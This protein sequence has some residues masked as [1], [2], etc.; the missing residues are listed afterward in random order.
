LNK[1]VLNQSS[2]TYLGS[3]RMPTYAN[4]WSTAFSTGGLTHRYVNGQLHF[5]TTSHVYSGGL[6]YETNYPGISTGDIYSAPQAQVVWNWGDVYTGK[7]ELQDAQVPGDHWTSQLSSGD[8]TYGLYY[9]QD[10]GRLYW[11]YGDWYN[12]DFPF[13]PS[14]GYSVLN[15]STG[16]V[17]GVGTWSLTD[18]PE[19]FTR[20]GTLRIPQWFADSYTG[21]RSLGVGFGGYFSIMSGGSWGPALAAVSDPDINASP[22]RSALNNVPLLGYPGNAP[23][24]CHRDADYTSFYDSGTYPTTTGQWNS[25]NGTG[26]WTWSDIIYG[27]SAWIDMPQLGGVLFIAKVGQGNV[28]YES[29]DRHAQRGTFEWFVYD[30]KD[31]AAVATG[32]KQQW[33]IQPKYEWTDNTLPIGLDQSGW[34]GDGFNQVGGV[35]FDST[36]NRLYVLVNGSWKDGCCEW[37]PQVYVYQVQP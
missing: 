9:D 6:V 20:G 28:W 23:D 13:N 14:F 1:P 10:L 29:S 12:A 33:Q 19:H 7:K 35:T 30:P 26:Y 15:D 32:A 3:F 5:L 8:P 27:S 16:V 11:S 17:T 34:S 24:R 37:Y 22:D 25:S 2:F 36:T 31:I 21:G 18:R 4:S